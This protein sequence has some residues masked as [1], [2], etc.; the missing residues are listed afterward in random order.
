MTCLF[1]GERKESNGNGGQDEKHN[2]DSQNGSPRDWDDSHRWKTTTWAWAPPGTSTSAS[3][4]LSWLFP[5]F[6]V[7]AV[8]VVVVVVVR[9]ATKTNLLHRTD[10]RSFTLTLPFRNSPSFYFKIS[11]SP[12]SPVLV[13]GPFFLST[14]SC[15]F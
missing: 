8:V 10:H 5:I 14:I 4:R 13:W 6:L 9:D 1:K 12:F 11:K 3:T 2:Q 15:Q 7:H